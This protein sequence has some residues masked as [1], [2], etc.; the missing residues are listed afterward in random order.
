VTAASAV[1]RRALGESRVRNLSFAAFFALIAYANVVGYRNTYST[2]AER[3]QFATSFG[4]NKALRLFYGAPHDL[5]SVGGYAAWRVGGTMA[6]AAGIWGVLA[7]VKAMRA[8][9]EAG[10][11]ELVLA[12]TVTR[13]RRSERRWRR[14]RWAQRS[15]GWHSSPDSP[16]GTSR[17]AARPSSH[18]RRSRPRSFSSASAR[19]P[20]R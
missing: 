8:E 1:A 4:A 3:L 13:G 15:C 17:R 16:R 11:L 6:I 20:A 18:S 14:A 7:A 9:E 12:G 10:R 5:L 2:F 19:L